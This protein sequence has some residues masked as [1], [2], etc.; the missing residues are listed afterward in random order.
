MTFTADDRKRVMV[1]RELADA[2]LKEGP[3]EFEQ[4][5]ETI[6]VTKEDIPK[7]SPN[8]CCFRS[9]NMRDSG[10]NEI[11]YEC[12]RVF[13]AIYNHLKGFDESHADEKI[14]VFIPTDEFLG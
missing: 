12:G 14:I 6:V 3:Q 10:E 5:G 1:P 8:D 2:V 11:C 7:E 13:D 9:A 4:D